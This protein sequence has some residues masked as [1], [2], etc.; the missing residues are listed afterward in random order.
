MDFDYFFKNFNSNKPKK[1]KLKDIIYLILLFLLFV[2]ISW[3][4]VTSIIYRFKNPKKTETEVL[5]HIP[6]SF[7]LNFK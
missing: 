4:A 1:K 7:I 3:N 5:L 2:V 6:K